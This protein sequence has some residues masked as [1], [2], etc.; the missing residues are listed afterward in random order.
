MGIDI[1][2]IKDYDW[3]M[4]RLREIRQSKFMSQKDV[5]EKS[6]LT[7]STISLIENEITTRPNWITINALAK[8]LDIEPQ[9]LQFSM[10]DK[11]K[12]NSQ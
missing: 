10:C 11:N 7:E 9:E 3:N 4:N 8:A 12:V 6:G 1:Y 5:A 2:K